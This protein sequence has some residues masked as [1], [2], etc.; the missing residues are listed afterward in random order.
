[1]KSVNLTRKTKETDIT[2]TLGDCETKISTGVG[3]FDHM[4]TA[5][6]FYAGINANLNVTGD[7]EVDAHH[8]VEDTGIVIGEAL[9]EAL[10][11]TAGIR[12]FAHSFI[13]MDEALILCALD[14]SGRAYLGFDAVFAQEKIGGYD[15]CLTEEFFRALS[16]HG[17]FT[18]HLRQISGN[19][20]HHVT[21][22]IFKAFGVA[23]REAITVTGTGVTSTKGVL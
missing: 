12:R 20:A 5:F 16:L 8:T 21:E 11:D 13:P 2:L 1:V 10:G 9:R 14:I 17:G 19:N 6:F 23:L 7:L 18:L 4:L 3:F 15:S 22:A